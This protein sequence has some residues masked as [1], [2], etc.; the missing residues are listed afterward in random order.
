M[1][2]DIESRINEAEVCRSM[3]LYGD[4]LS[5]Y[6]S[7]LTIVSPG[8]AESHD[9]I[10]KRIGV[11]KKEIAQQD[12][13]QPAGVSAKN[14]SMLKKSFSGQGDVAE[15]LD[16]ASAF[17]EMGL[18]AEAVSEYVKIFKED[19]P[20]DKIVPG[21]VESLLK[22]H[23]PTNAVKEFDKLI[24]AQKIDKKHLARIKFVIGQELEKRD[25]R[26]QAHDLYTDASKLDTAN[27]DIKKRL[28]SVSATF[29]TGSKYDYLLREELVTTDKLQTGFC[30]VQKDEKKCG[31]CVDRAF[32]CQQRSHRQIFLLIL[33]LP[34]QAFR[35]GISR[36]GGI[37]VQSQKSVF[38]QRAVDSDKL[39][40]AGC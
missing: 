24:K 3:G 20:V 5:I 4:S 15:L 28:D 33:R 21:L 40:Q 37:V 13:S 25:L 39:G 38:A 23:S 8:D 30:P 34:F 19:H 31:T 14:I 35:R 26:D 11:L 17:Q 9:K 18:H 10:Q 32:S 36:T 29:A 16:S 27:A 22:I 7:I 1:R 2:T 12:D 6:E